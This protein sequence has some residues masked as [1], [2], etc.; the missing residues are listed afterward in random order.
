MTDIKWILVDAN[1]DLPE[2]EVLAVKQNYIN[3]SRLRH[4]LSGV[5]VEDCDGREMSRV[6]AYIPVDHLRQLWATQN[7]AAHYSRESVPC[8]LLQ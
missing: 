8:E 3:V 7:P 1:S 2:D 4:D 6:E 5:T